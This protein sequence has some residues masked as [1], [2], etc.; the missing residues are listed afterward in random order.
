MF[1]CVTKTVNGRAKP[2]MFIANMIKK[3]NG[4]H[5]TQDIIE[6]IGS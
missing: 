1:Y 3:T 4:K 5:N 6:Q 2:K